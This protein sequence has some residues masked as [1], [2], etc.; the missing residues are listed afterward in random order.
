MKNP[1]AFFA[2]GGVLALTLW[3]IV[4]WI[5]VLIATPIVWTYDRLCEVFHGR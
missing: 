1:P 3:V 4:V 5:V 2:F